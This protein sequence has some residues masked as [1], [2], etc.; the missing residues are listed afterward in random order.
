MLTSLRISNY[1]AF[2]ELR[3]DELS[4]I[5][6]ISGR[7]NSGK[8]TLL[9]ALLMLSSG[10]PEITL[11]SSIIRGMRSERLPPAAIPSIFW[12]QMFSS[13][14]FGIPIEISADSESSGCLGMRLEL[15][16]EDII[17]TSLTTS[18]E[19]L[20]G[21]ELQDPKLLATIRRGDDRWQRRIQVTDKEI[22]MERRNRPV[23]FPASIVPSGIGDLK[24]DAECLD[25]LKKQ[26]QGHRVV[27]ALQI[28][29][30]YLKSLEV[31]SQTGSPLIW[32][33]TGLSELVPLT[34]AGEGMIRISRLA[35]C[36]VLAPGGVLLVDEIENGMHHSIATAV[37]RFILDTARELDVQVFSTTHS[38]E[39][40][41]AAQALHSDDLMLHRLETDENGHRCV[42]V[43]PEQLETAVLHNLEVR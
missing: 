35:M 4:R 15:E 11:H 3:M 29:D 22:H 37:W 31:I 7:N 38:Y 28:V 21:E 39:C 41:Q 36:M 17:K 6:L 9:E 19:V 24:S 34:T 33:D 23:L 14:N 40:V 42:T 2:R 43:R 16:H 12:R 1:R 30:P 26:K 10:H 18:N 32:A 25:A 13:L 27:E 5:N 8:T 20:L